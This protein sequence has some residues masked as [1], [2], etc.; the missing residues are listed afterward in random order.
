MGDT[1]KFA[2]LAEDPIDMPPEET[3]YQVMVHPDEVAFICELAPQAIVEGVAEALVGAGGS[4]TVTVTGVLVVL[5][6][7]E[8]LA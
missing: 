2:A 1:A 8:L 4:E 7:V 5:E 3:V 6:Q